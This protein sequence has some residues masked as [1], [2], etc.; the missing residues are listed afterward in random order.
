MSTAYVV[1]G[2]G[3]G[4]EG[5]GMTTAQIAKTKHQTNLYT[6]RMNGGAQAG[7]TVQFNNRRT[8]F[9][10]VSSATPVGARATIYTDDV[11]V[12]PHAIVTECIATR[13]NYGVTPFVLVGENNPIST[14]FDVHVNQIVSRHL[15]KTDTC[16][17]G[18]NNTI[19]RHECIPLTLQQLFSGEDVT[20]TLK[21]IRNYYKSHLELYGIPASNFGRIFSDEFILAATRGLLGRINAV[22]HVTLSQF[23]ESRGNNEKEFDKEDSNFIFEGAQGLFLDQNHGVFPFVTPSNT[24]CT[25]AISFL[26]KLTHKPK[27]Q[28]VYCT[29]TFLTRHGDG[30]FEVANPF[31]DEIHYFDETN[32]Q[33]EFQGK[34]KIGILDV[35]K[36]TK[37]INLDTSY[38]KANYHDV[39]EPVLSVS[40]ADLFNYTD[41]KVK[42]NG[43]I[44]IVKNFDEFKN[45]MPFPIAIEGHG[46]DLNEWKTTMEI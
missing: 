44:H 29:R 45:L 35:D 11:V 7:H 18:I 28:P 39:A 13:H 5:K 31:I 10:T 17:F 20:K 25:N 23:I 42:A 46:V 33:N 41:I 32:L 22:C 9:Q 27:L 24:G 21:E 8:V 12:N 34:F 19:R 36:M 3:F 43:E 40:H 1:I 4:D 15:G 14:S 6:L 37:F 38:A 16:G 26:N 30:P 2:A